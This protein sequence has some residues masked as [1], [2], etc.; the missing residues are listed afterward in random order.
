MNDRLLIIGADGLLG[1]ALRSHCRAVG[2]ENIVSSRRP[3]TGESGTVTLDLALPASAWPDFTS[4]K[5]AVLCAGI[6]SLDQCRKNPAL[7]SHINVAQTIKLAHTL[8]EA[9]VFTT[10]ISTNLVFDGSKPLR[11]VSDQPCPG[12]EY[13]RQKME[14]EKALVQLG[15]QVAIVR[16]TKVIHRQMQLIQD[17]K[18]QLSEGR[19]ITPFDDLVCSPITLP[20]TVDAITT[21]A[22]NQKYGIWHLSS[23]TDISYAAI[24]RQ[25]AELHQLD[26]SLIRPASCRTRTDWEHVPAHT[27]L[28][29][30][31]S[32]AEIGF[33]IKSPA[34][35][36][37]ETFTP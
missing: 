7:T 31:R 3:A 6:T 21:I 34:D 33:H 26:E 11:P 14:V 25:I 1:S 17:W 20:A 29:A 30:S 28:D 13:G 15:K 16:L 4:Y 32:V 10:F 19:A 36:I 24:A 2:I 18:N 5:S 37:R 35:T 27:T 22:I 9:G 8:A 23:D 12:T